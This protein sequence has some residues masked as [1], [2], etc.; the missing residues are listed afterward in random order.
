MIFLLW[1]FL[2]PSILSSLTS[3]KIIFLK[4]ESNLKQNIALAGVA[5]WLAHRPGDRGV[6]LPCLPPC[7]EHRLVGD[8]FLV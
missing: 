8:V 6:F 1:M 3:I 7:L 4:N 2:S 5:Q